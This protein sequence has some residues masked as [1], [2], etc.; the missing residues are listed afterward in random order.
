MGM[1]DPKDP[2]PYPVEPAPEGEPA[3][4]RPSRADEGAREP[5]IDE[6]GLLDEFDE[7]ADFTSDPELE[8]AIAAGARPPAAKELPTGEPL[9]PGPPMVKGGGVA[10]RVLV[11]AAGVA[12][13]VAITEALIWQELGRW[14][15]VGLTIYGA[16]LNTALGLAA[17]YLA[18]RLL[19]RRLRDFERAGAR[20]AFAACL[21]QVAAQ[22]Q[23]HMVGTRENQIEELILATAVY[24]LALWG[25]FRWDAR[26]LGAV[27]GLHFLGWL[28]IKTGAALQ[29]CAAT[30]AVGG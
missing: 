17:I 15:Q 2:T 23:I 21:S 5:R 19:D 30:A 10:D 9:P 26:T 18:A 7:E 8:A 12:L 24:A 22:L 20:V 25:L 6:P 28:V 1:G 3:A 11:I 16:L 14:P 29:S 4:D 13:L 27:L